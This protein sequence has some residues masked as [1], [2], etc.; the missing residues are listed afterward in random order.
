MR[1]RLKGLKTVTKR[2]A[3]GQIVRYWYAWRGGP[4]LDGRPG[5]TEFIAS[6]N[7]AVAELPKAQIGT[8]DFILDKFQDSDAFLS[9]APRTQSDYRKLLRT[10]ASEFGDFP[11]AALADRKARGS[12]NGGTALQSALAGKPTMPGACWHGFCHGRLT[13]A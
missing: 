11:L 13:V 6:Y 1:V 10:I 7:R 9:R 2:L 12:W 8:L 5:S 4:R 3:D